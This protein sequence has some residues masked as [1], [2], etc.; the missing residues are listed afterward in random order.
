M[1]ET[2]SA[3]QANQAQLLDSI[4]LAINELK[5]TQS[6]STTKIQEQLQRQQQ[7]LLLAKQQHLLHAQQQQLLRQV[8]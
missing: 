3:S 2:R 4:L 1:A 6:D 8:C 5:T 7:Q